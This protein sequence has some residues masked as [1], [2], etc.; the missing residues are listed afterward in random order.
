M[1]NQRAMFNDMVWDEMKRQKTVSKNKIKAGTNI[2]KMNN[3]WLYQY[4]NYSRA[5][6]K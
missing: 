2:A 1:E 3:T 4:G 6:A 5:K